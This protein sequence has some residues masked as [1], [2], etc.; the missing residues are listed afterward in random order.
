MTGLVVNA[1]VKPKT[2]KTNARR[3][4]SIPR[5]KLSSVMR[6]SPHSNQSVSPFPNR[7][8]ALAVD[9]KMAQ[10]GINSNK[11]RFN[12]CPVNS[13]NRIKSPLPMK[14]MI[15]RL[16]TNIIAMHSSSD[17]PNFRLGLTR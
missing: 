2:A 17:M 12:G 4:I 6:I 11:I 9:T 14:A 13:R 1:K 7:I 15:S 5:K 8:M 16:R 3:P 10:K